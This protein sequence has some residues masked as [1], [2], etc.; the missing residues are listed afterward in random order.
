MLNYWIDGRADLNL[1][2]QAE[3]VNLTLKLDKTR[4]ITRF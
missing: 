2:K 3:S 1:C 4:N